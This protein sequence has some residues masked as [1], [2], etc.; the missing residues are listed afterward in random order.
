MRY[1]KKR[2]SVSSL[3][4][5]AFLIATFIFSHFAQAATITIVNLDG[6]GEGL[7][8]PTPVAPV[9]GNP[10]TTL[11]AQRLNA[12]QFAAGLWSARLESNIEIR[13]DANFDP[14]SPCSNTSGTLANAG[15]T[16][17]VRDFTGTPVANTWF[18]IALA[19][20]LAGVDLDPAA[21]DIDAT[22]NSKVGT[23]GC[24]PTLGWYYGFDA[25]PPGNEI[26][27]ISNVLHELA[28]GLGFDTFFNLATGAK[29]MGFA[30]TFMRFLEDHSTGKLY[31]NITNGE[32][33]TASTNTGNLHWVGPNVVAAGDFLIAGRDPVSG[34]VEMF[35]PNPQQPGSSV[36]H[37]SDA[38][39]PDELME[40]FYAGPNHNLN[41]TAAL[42]KD[43]G[44]QTLDQAVPVG[45]LENPQNGSTASGISAISGWICAA[46]QVTLQ[47]DGVPALAAYGTSRKDT[48][49]VCGDENNGFGLLINWNLLGNGLHT[50]V[51]FA[52]GVE[53]AQA[54]FTVATLGQEFLTGASGTYVVPNFAGR[55]VIIQWQESLQN[56]V[57]I[58]TQ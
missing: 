30:D 9:G 48:I 15:P 26:D 54:T 45:V 32:R 57:I 8:D 33:V 5:P 18:S 29:L 44:W 37:F 55:N 25:N 2:L 28:H 42:L 12:L 21:D 19:N 20:S 24:L 1:H 23:A 50:I 31:P 35:A 38:L 11:G 58:G 43:T 47:I 4:A 27:F 39:F 36:F 40:P 56:F 53:F 7:N 17:V 10:G 14:L 22:F 51:A 13:V 52:D 6:P 16:K 41:L 3:L 46:I 49:P 34:H